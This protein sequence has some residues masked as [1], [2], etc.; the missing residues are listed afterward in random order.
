MLEDLAS[1]KGFAFNTK[2]EWFDFKMSGGEQ[3]LK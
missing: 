2:K 3:K 1:F